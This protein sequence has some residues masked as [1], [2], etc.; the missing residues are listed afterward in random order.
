MRFMPRIALC[1][2]NMSISLQPLS[3]VGS[4]RYRKNLPSNDACLRC[5]RSVP[6]LAAPGS[7]HPADQQEEASL[8]TGC[9]AR[10]GGKAL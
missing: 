10:L 9:Y 4:Y 1:C 6:L 7:A 8:T 3:W 5:H 2:M